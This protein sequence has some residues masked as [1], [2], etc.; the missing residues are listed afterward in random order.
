LNR[1]I[2]QAAKGYPLTVHG[3]GG[4]TR[5]FIDIRDTVR[6][7]E[8]AALNPADRGE[9]RV[10]NQF[11][12]QWSVLQ[13]AERVR[14][15]ASAMGMETIVDH[16]DNPRVEKEQHYYNAKHTKL[17]DLGLEPHLLTDETIRIL[18]AKAVRFRD[19][20]NLEQVPA[21][22]LWR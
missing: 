12:E 20:I 8:L 21:R 7:I 13:L 9:L 18:L 14:D 17:L 15:V 19:R 11:T 3:E 10:Y 4:Q 16:V 2:S 1:F 6:C 22:V 5:G